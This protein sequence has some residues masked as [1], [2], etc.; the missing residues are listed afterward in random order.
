MGGNTIQL[1]LMNGVLPFVFYYAKEHANEGLM[2]QCI[3]QMNSMKPEKNSIIS[4]WKSL[5]LKADSACDSQALLW[6]RKKYCN[7]KQC[8]RCNIG[9]QL[10]SSN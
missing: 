4:H 3:D 1:I 8:L 2:Q 6:L 5:G 7:E 9:H 10:L